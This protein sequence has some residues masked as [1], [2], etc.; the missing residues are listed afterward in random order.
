MLSPATAGSKL[1]IPI[2]LNLA[3]PLKFASTVDERT[4]K[5]LCL[6]GQFVILRGSYYALGKP[7]L[8]MAG[9]EGIK[10]YAQLPI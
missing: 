3:V 7:S 2:I 8:V 10:P 4:F 1:G 5:F 9:A 6:S